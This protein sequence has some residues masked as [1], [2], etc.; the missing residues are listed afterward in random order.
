MAA[1]LFELRSKVASC[2]DV[3]SR[4]YLVVGSIVASL[5]AVASSR[6]GRERGTLLDHILQAHRLHFLIQAVM[7]RTTRIC[8]TST[9]GRAE[10]LQ[11]PAH[12]FTQFT[13]KAPLRLP[14]ENSPGLVARQ[15]HRWYLVGDGVDDRRLLVGPCD[16]K[17][18]VNEVDD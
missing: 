9:P 10:P 14:T 3:Q 16:F 17:N 13:F 11:I 1:S 15:R 6:G 8:L 7:G 2:C 5:A 18:A 4:Q 12:S